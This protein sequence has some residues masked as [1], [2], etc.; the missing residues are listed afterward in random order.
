MMHSNNTIDLAHDYGE[1]EL[2]EDLKE[3]WHLRRSLTG[4]HPQ[5]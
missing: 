2:K 4:L 3:Y 5:P 1:Y